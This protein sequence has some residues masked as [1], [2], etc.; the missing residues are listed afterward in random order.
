[1]CSWLGWSP[2]LCPSLGRA[3]GWGPAPE[4]RGAKARLHPAS[5]SPRWLDELSKR[6]CLL[7]SHRNCSLPPSEAQDALAFLEESIKYGQCPHSPHWPSCHPRPSRGC[8]SGPASV[9]LFNRSFNSDF[10]RRVLFK[11]STLTS[12]NRL[13]DQ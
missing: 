13:F 12:H 8:V 7:F 10:P 6:A 9:S 2:S 1:M 4:G 11:P 5:S 3:V